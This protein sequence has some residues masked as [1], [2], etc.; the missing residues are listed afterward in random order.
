ME[1]LLRTRSLIDGVVNTDSSV[2][3]AEVSIAI[4]GEAQWFDFPPNSTNVTVLI[5]FLF[6]THA[7][8]YS[9]NRY[10]FMQM[11]LA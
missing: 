6:H 8:Q 4:E 9:R 11:N 3:S 10:R 7:F 5:V 1:R 2:A